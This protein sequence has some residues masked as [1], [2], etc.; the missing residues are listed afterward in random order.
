MI[1]VFSYDVYDNGEGGVINRRIKFKA[2]VEDM[3]GL[4]MLSNDLR[5]FHIKETGLKSVSIMLRYTDKRE[6]KRKIWV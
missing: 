3:E 1:E 5:L 6:Q 2:E 4:K